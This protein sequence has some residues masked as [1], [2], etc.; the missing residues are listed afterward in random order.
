MLDTFHQ[1]KITLAP[2]AF[3][4]LPEHV[5][6]DPPFDWTRRAADYVS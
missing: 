2:A 3:K 6:S 4:D 5:A 1:G